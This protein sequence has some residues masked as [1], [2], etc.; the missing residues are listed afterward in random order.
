MLYNKLPDEL[1]SI[2]KALSDK[3]S[4]LVYHTNNNVN[5]DLQRCRNCKTATLNHMEGTNE[6]CCQ[7][8]GLL[9]PLEGVA[10]NYNEVYQYGDYKVNKPKRS[11]R[12]YNFK[13]FLDKHVKNCAEQGFILSCDTIQYARE[14]F[15]NI[16]SALPRRISLAFVAFKIFQNLAKDNERF[17]LKYFL[18]HV[19][20]KA[21]ERYEEKW[22]EMLR[23]YSNL[24]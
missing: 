14:C 10:F 3:P 16:D 17:I 6:L 2:K 19:P 8:C 1:H 4:D 20:T 23:H 11:N 21:I 9:E 7:N 12:R 15:E 24:R 18:M 22:E 5:C 13:Y